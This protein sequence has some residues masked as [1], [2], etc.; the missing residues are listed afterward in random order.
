MISLMN[1]VVFPGNSPNNKKWSDGLKESFSNSFPKISAL[2]YDHWK[3]GESLI[4]LKTELGKLAKL[5]EGKS[6]YAVFAKSFG[7]FLATR[8]ILEDIN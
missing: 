8:A 6:K 7:T 5:I 4:N 2:D 3:N 1:L